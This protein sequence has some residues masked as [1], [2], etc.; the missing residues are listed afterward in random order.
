MT[1]TD[2]RGKQ[3]VRE[4]VSYRKQFDGALRTVVFYLTPANVRDTA[5]LTWDYTDASREDEQWL[6]LPA[7]R[8]S[9]RI[10]AADRGDYFL[11]TDFTFEDIKLD[12][13]LSEDD[14]RFTLEGSLQDGEFLLYRLVGEPRS[15]TL[16]KELGYSRLEVEVDASSWLATSVDF[17]DPSGQP[18]KSLE[19]T[20][21]S[22]VDGV[23][24]RSGLTVNNLQT[25]HQTRFE[26]YEIDYSTD[27]DKALFTRQALE[28]G[29]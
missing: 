2:S 18:L 12:G 20:G 9:R 13:K 28:R 5:F 19:V 23:W 29:L 6:Y 10:P 16:A 27:I 22:E 8:K 21:I 24:T 3:R 1:L 11:G 26:F 15:D 25:G 7:L 4:T 14:Y 17:F